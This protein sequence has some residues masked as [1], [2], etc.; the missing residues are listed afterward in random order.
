MSSE[1]PEA[2]FW[3]VWNPKGRLPTFQHPSPGSARAEASRLAR[4]NV[5]Q[6]FFVLGSIEVVEV[7]DPVEVKK[8]APPP[9]IE[10]DEI[11]F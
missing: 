1:T 6:K 11:P 8:L 5:G 3:M 4:A 7:P 9:G 2:M 10:L